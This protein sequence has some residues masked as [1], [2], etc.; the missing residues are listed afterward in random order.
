MFRIKEDE[1]GAPL[2][3]T[4]GPILLIHGMFSEPMDWLARKDETLPSIAVQLSQLGY[5]VWIG[6]PRGRKYTETNSNLDRSVPEDE[7]KFWDYTYAEI[8][9]D[10]IQTMIT[11]I[12]EERFD[13]DCSK[14]AVLTHSTAANSAL[15]A[16]S[17]DT[18]FWSQRVSAIISLAPCFMV[19]LQQY[20]LPVRDLASV[21]AFYV[22]ILSSGVYSLFGE[23]ME[24]DLTS[25]CSQ[26]PQQQA[27]C[28]HYLLPH[29]GDEKWKQSGV[30][31][32]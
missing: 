19:D 9:S 2:M 5:D 14:V 24:S 15:T 22:T 4:L 10:D 13:R 25:Y 1:T 8:G 16:A 27:I 31:E 23:E 26:G 17:M 11:T 32:M 30:R 18:E 6:C 21:D 20:W 3:D 28:Q 29:L 12:I 7:A